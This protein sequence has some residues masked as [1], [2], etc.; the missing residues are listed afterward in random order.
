MS[1]TDGGQALIYNLVFG[2]SVWK[3]IFVLYRERFAFTFSKNISNC[4]ICCIHKAMNRRGKGGGTPDTQRE[5]CT[6][7]V[8]QMVELLYI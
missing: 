1:K 5:M 7:F 8:Q 4:K 2:I 3:N 6:R